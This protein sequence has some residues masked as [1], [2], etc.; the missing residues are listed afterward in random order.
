MSKCF[1]KDQQ[2]DVLDLGEQCA[3]TPRGRIR[4]PRVRKTVPGH[5]GR[6]IN[7]FM[8]YRSKVQAD[9]RQ[10]CPTANHRVI[11]KIIAKWWKAI[12]EKEKDVYRVI[13]DQAKKDHLEKHPGYTFRPKP[14][15]NK[16]PTA[17]KAKEAV[18]SATQEDV[19]DPDYIPSPLFSCKVE[20]DYHYQQQSQQQAQLGYVDTAMNEDASS[21]YFQ[22]I[23]NYAPVPLEEDSLNLDTNNATMYVDPA[24][25]HND[26]M[27]INAAE[28]IPFDFEA[29]PAMFAL[30][31]NSTPASQMLETPSLEYYQSPVS[32]SH[33]LLGHQVGFQQTIQ[34]AMQHQHQQQQQQEQQ[35]DTPHLLDYTVI[36][37]GYSN[38]YGKLFDSLDSSSSVSSSDLLHTPISNTQANNDFV[39]FIYGTGNPNIIF[40]E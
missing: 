28:P 16:K 9:I 25:L 33:P 15:K 22:S 7:S 4:K 18:K 19:K 26:Y 29:D 2:K 5:I 27:D 37:A 21:C 12:D 38:E 6:P 31:A 24:L 1:T 35:L 14:K 10:F 3:K 32:L 30:L 8:A 20:K 34:Q 23:A 40:L 11:S 17:T 13:A 36:P 39:N